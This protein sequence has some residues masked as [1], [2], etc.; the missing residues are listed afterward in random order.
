MGMGMGIKGA[1]IR[2]ASASFGSAGL[3]AGFALED[4]VT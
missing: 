2:G 1:Y 4:I 3:E